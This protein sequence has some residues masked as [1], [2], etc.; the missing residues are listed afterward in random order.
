MLG[1]HESSD[2]LRGHIK[3]CGGESYTAER[4]IK[5]NSPKLL[6][7]ERGASW[8]TK[9]RRWLRFGAWSWGCKSGE[10]DGYPGVSEAVD[11]LLVPAWTSVSQ[12]KVI[13]EV[14]CL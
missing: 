11:M 9:M 5:V 3:K 2:E 6:W 10:A 13:L 14:L 8:C 12:A 7:A 4:R 1:E